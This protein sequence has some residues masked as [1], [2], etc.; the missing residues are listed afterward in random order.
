MSRFRETSARFPLPTSRGGL[1]KIQVILFDL[2][3]SIL[4]DQSF[5]TSDG[6]EVNP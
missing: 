6:G 2:S 3:G 1:R 4:V 5:V